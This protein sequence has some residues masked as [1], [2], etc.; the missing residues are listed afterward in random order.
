MVLNGT[1]WFSYRAGY[2]R[3][4]MILYC[5]PCVFKNWSAY[6]YPSGLVLHC[7]NMIVVMISMMCFICV[8]YNIS[9]AVCQPISV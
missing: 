8:D 9:E 6:E 3:L 7:D 5:A 4:S 1:Q 2:M